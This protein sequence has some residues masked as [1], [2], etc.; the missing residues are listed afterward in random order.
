MLGRDSYSDKFLIDI[1]YDIKQYAFDNRFICILQNKDDEDFYYI[2]DSEK[3]I[4]L[5]DLSKQDYDKK[6]QEL[7]LNLVLK[8]I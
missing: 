2:I 1:G 5:A 6:I 4:I 8:D 7:N 3:N